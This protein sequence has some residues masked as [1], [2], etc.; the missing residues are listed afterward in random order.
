MAKDKK[1]K[2]PMEKLTKGYE[3]YIAKKEVSKNGWK[4]FS[5]TL[6]KA[7]KQRDSK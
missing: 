1:E 3:K 7:A 4:A 2:T 5:L 6:K